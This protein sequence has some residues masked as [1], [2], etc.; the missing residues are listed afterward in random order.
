MQAEI[1]E[2]VINLDERVVIAKE[3]EV[4]AEKLII[5]FSPFLRRQAAR[6]SATNDEHQRETLFSVAMSAFYEAIKNYNSEKGHFFPFAE[7]ITRSRIIDNLRETSR[8]EGKLVSLYDDDEEQQEQSAAITEISLLR[9]DMERK[10][11]MVAEEVEQF[12]AEISEWGITMDALVKA[13]PKHKELRKTYYDIL[14]A[15]SEDTEIMQT[16]QQKRYFPIKAISIITGLPQKKLER[17][18]I[19]IIASLIIKT[20][21]YDLLSDFLHR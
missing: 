4:E 20:G 11:E 1:E 5:E 2:N 15:V 21:D 8:H 18:R 19:F 16:I 13:S 9:Y 14:A 17:A 3:S 10:R 6:Y 7:R 12:K